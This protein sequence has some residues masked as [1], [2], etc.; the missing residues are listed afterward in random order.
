METVILVVDDSPVD[1]SLV[2]LMLQKARPD[3]M[4]M[5]VES[6]AGA[7]A[8]L[9]RQAVSLV[10]TDLQMPE[11]NGIELT[12]AIRRI[13]P[14]LPVILMTAYGSEWI[15][16][17]AFKEGATDYVPKKDLRAALLL[18]VEAALQEVA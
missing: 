2:S 7:L 8:V 1:R 3:W 5:D 6:G 15:A 13:Y 4:V 17:N 9:E 11:V 12:R 14:R 16:R 10:L 18:T